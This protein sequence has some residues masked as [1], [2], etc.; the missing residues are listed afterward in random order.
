MPYTPEVDGPDLLG[1][2]IRQPSRR[3][4]QRTRRPAAGNPHGIRFAFY[5]RMSTKEFQDRLS[6]A[7]WQ[8]NFAEELING[9]GVI[10][11]EFFDAG[12]S[13][14]LPWPQR[15]QA[16]RLL[17]SLADPDRG[18]D[19]IVVGEF[20]RA[21][22][23]DQFRALAPLFT[24]YGVELWLPELHGPVDAGNELHLSLLALLGVHSQREIQRS[25]FR[26]KA[27]MRAQVIEQ[28]RHLG[29]RPPYGYRLV[30][31][32]PHPNRAHAKWGRQAQRLQP[33]PAT[34]PHVQWMFAQRLA[35]RSV[36][37]IARDLNARRV[38]CPSRADPDRNPHRSGAGW[39]L[40]TVA[41]ILANPRYTGRQVWNRQPS[42]RGPLDTADDL[43]GRSDARRW[44]TLQQWVISREVAHPPLV[45]EQD[46]VAAQQTSA[47]LTP[48]DG[49]TDRYLLNGMVTCQVCGR[50]LRLALGEQPRR[51]PVPP[52]HQK[53][54]PRR[55]R[56]P[57][58]RLHPR[59]QS[60]QPARGLARPAAVQPPRHRR[61]AS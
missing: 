7:R 46:F 3:G 60:H 19:A 54:H 6:S 61:R 58:Q 47:V 11:A 9:R 40:R 39:T 12:C 36:A 57:A 52:R 51:L 43:L 48:A 32:G 23:G 55:R 38:P 24:L 14:R 5:G 31:A 16:A 37:G 27:A 50:I 17:A 1:W 8:R 29:G 28:G 45:S 35:G 26:A 34:A 2:W 49:N 53:S 25:R 15:P 4:R 13:R 22:Y 18:F 33:D 44:S 59:S 10:V 42:D 56:S 30:D 41:P 21:F 20:E